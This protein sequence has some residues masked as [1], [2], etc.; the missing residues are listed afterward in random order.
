MRIL[1]RFKYC[2][3]CGSSHISPNSWKSLLCE[4]CGFEYFVNPSGSTAAFILND[5]GEMLVTERRREPAKGT[6]DLPGGFADVG[7]TAE[8]GIAREV[9][10]ETGLTVVSSEYMF[11]YPNKYYYSGIDIPTLDLFFL[12]KVRDFGEMRADDD[13]KSLVWM[14]LKDIH[15]EQFGLRSIRN[16]LIRFLEERRSEEGSDAK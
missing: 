8:E 2:P 6:Y 16:G 10:E 11:S 4:A 5:K 3:V 1:D 13:V 9:K 7:E 12:C 14:P 15:T